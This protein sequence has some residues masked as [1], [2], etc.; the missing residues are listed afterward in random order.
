MF[1]V[2]TIAIGSEILSGQI[3]DTNTHWVCAQVA[4]MGGTVDRAHILGDSVAAVAEVLRAALRRKPDA[5]V[6][7]GGL[8]PTSDDL[9]LFAVAGAMNRKMALHPRA[10][11]WV[12]R[13]Y[14][15]LA[16]AGFVESPEMTPARQKMAYLPEGA[17]PLPNPVGAA[18]A[19]RVPDEGG[20]VICLPGV[21]AEMRA[22][23]EQSVAPAW[24]K[25]FG[26]AG[27]AHREVWAECGDESALAPPLQRISDE[28][29][30]VYVKS[31][32]RRFGPDTRVLVTLSSSGSTQTEAAARV[33]AALGSLRKALDEAGIALLEE[34]EAAPPPSP[35]DE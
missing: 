29:P 11:E 33:E 23:F 30:E 9:T 32:A 15:E 1:T 2:E 10:Q 28:S 3:L 20:E 19:V 7:F 5:I 14:E 8:G 13:R 17:E 4:G 34:A 31:R 22:V 26:A 21:P 27:F 16:R 6:T 18:P 24:R 35:P 25:R 12:R